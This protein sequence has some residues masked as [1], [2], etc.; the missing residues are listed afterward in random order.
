[1]LTTFIVW[2]N[3]LTH[4]I[5]AIE[6]NLYKF[7]SMAAIRCVNWCFN[8]SNMAEAKQKICPSKVASTQ[9]PSVSLFLKQP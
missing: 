2:S 1:M 7:P 8:E 5:A 6:G 3:Q 9:L 4:L